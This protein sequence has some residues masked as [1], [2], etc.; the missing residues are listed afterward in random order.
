M[1]ANPYSII[2]GQE[3]EEMISRL[4]DI[5]KITESF[6]SE[7]PSQNVYMISGVRGAGKTVFLT[8]VANRFKAMDN[9]IVVDLSSEGDMMLDLAAELASEKHLAQIFQ[10]AEI[11]LSFWGFGL[12]VKNSVPI[13]S[14]KVALTKMLES[15]SAQGKRVLVTIDEVVSNAA[16]RTFASNYQI[17]TRNKLPIYLLM[18]GL[19]ENI[20]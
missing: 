19:F 2:F 12:K 5:V 4:S 18:T 15:L 1:S 13:T 16:M 6:Q 7:K 9:W 14:L 10:N 8:E 17:F 11:N 3:P 20:R